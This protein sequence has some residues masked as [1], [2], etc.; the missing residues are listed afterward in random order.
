[1]ELTIHKFTVDYV[2]KLYMGYIALDV[3]LGMLFNV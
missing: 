1:V 2:C 3:C